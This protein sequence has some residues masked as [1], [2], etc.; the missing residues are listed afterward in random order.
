MSI[1][2]VIDLCCS[3]VVTR[4][5]G[6]VSGADVQQYLRELRAHP[7]FE[8]EYPRIVD[9]RRTTQMP[10]AAE[11]RMIAQTAPAIEPGSGR[12]ALIA[13][14]DYPYGM[15]RMFEIIAGIHSTTTE[16]RAF[17]DPASAADWLGLDQAV[18]AS[19]EGP[20]PDAP[21]A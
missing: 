10:T 4:M 13:D 12:R 20:D 3:C 5:W 14:R 9:M 8:A 18:T 2:F 17:R 6:E 15:L 21:P 16:Y 19:L 7:D 11:L 1:S